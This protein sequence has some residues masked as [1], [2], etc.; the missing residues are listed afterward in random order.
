MVQYYIAT[1]L[2]RA[3]DHNVVRDALRRCGHEITY[4][5]STHGDGPK[6]ESLKR[7]EEVAVAEIKGVEDADVL[8]VLLPGGGGT[9]LEMGVALALGKPVIIHCEDPVIFQLG[10]QTK[11]FYHLPL[12]TQVVTPMNQLRPLLDAFEQCAEGDLLRC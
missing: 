1:G 6:F 9:H 10:K 12:V 5:W 7:L 3:G 4:D 8:V 11:A 2:R